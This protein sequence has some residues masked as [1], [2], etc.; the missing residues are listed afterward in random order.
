M[1]EFN[2][3]IVGLGGIGNVVADNFYPF[4]RGVVCDAKLKRIVFIDKDRYEQSNVPRQK[5]AASMLGLNKA[6][7]WERIYSR[8]RVNNVNAGISHKEEWITPTTVSSCFDDVVSTGPTIIMSCV[9]NH[10]ARLLMSKYVQTRIADHNDLVLIQGGCSRGRATTDL[11]GKWNGVTVGTPIEVNHPEVTETRNGDRSGISCEELANSSTGDQ[12]YVENFMAGSMLINLMF[13]LL[14][15]PAALVPFEE[16]V[17]DIG[18]HYYLVNKRR[19]APPPG[20]K[21]V[22]GPAAPVCVDGAAE[23]PKDGKASE[24]PPAFTEQQLRAIEEAK[25][26]HSVLPVVASYIFA[27]NSS[28]RVS[29]TG[30]VDMDSPGPFLTNLTRRHVERSVVDRALSAFNRD[31]EALMTATRKIVEATQFMKGSND[32]EKFVE[33][34]KI[35][36]GNDVHSETARDCIIAES[37]ATTN[38]KE[39]R[40]AQQ[41]YNDYVNGSLDVNALIK[42]Y[43][44]GE[45]PLAFKVA[46]K[47]D[48]PESNPDDV[49]PPAATEGGEDV[50]LPGE[51]GD[52][53][54]PI[55]VTAE[56]VQNMTHDQMAELVARVARQSQRRRMAAAAGH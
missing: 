22:S 40:Q 49:A 5:A 55:N 11:F 23:A 20:Y 31:S 54:A 18:T 6:L 28:E 4:L 50:T 30:M 35:C 44:G 43:Q 48:T 15:N 14:I 7:A 25:A 38:P 24:E 21:R 1:K 19:P 3:I 36:R 32:P 8:S 45:D 27:N 9:D 26:C 13:T 42:K 53:D 52:D 46:A 51:Y 41:C 37:I 16:E 2:M 47:S 12:T 17:Y 39:R 29:L 34:L 56:D 10:P 33:L